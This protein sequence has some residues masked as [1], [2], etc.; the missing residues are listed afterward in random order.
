MSSYRVA[1][2]HNPK[3]PIFRAVKDFSGK[4]KETYNSPR[5]TNPRSILKSF[6]KVNYEAFTRKSSIITIVVVIIVIAI[7]ATFA[8]F[9]I[10]KHK[11]I[12]EGTVLLGGEDKCPECGSVPCVCVTNPTDE[13]YQEKIEISENDFLAGGNPDSTEPINDSNTESGIENFKAMSHKVKNN[14]LI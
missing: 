5:G 9:M 3:T 1:P 7:I 2:G 4:P 12:G 11:T 8:F 10:R 6:G 14:Y 13:I